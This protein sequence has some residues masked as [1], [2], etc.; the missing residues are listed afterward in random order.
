MS[1]RKIKNIIP[2]PNYSGK[3]RQVHGVLRNS[4]G[5]MVFSVIENENVIYKLTDVLDLPIKPNNIGRREFNKKWVTFLESQVVNSNY[6]GDLFMYC[7]HQEEQKL[8][9][10]SE[11]TINRA[12][13][14]YYRADK[15]GIPYQPYCKESKKKYQNTPG[16][17]LRTSTQHMEGSQGSRTRGMLTSLCCDTSLSSIDD[18]FKK[19]GGKCFAT[20]K[21]LDIN[22]RRSYQIDHMMAASAYNPLNNKNVVLLSTEANQRKKDQHPIKF[23]GIEKFKELCGLLGINPEDYEDENYIL[24]DNVLYYFNNNFDNV[25]YEWH[26]KINRNKD[27]FKKYLNKEISRIAKKDIYNRH[28]SLLNKMKEY[29]KKI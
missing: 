23:F 14:Q 28:T 17:K 20:G 9:E 2:K 4:E 24:N 26:F 5:F 25:I 11:F 27:S 13:T 7:T 15:D 1:K 29:E 6:I 10:I 22:E 3:F 21:I 16:N 18:I 8:L 19:Y 12:N